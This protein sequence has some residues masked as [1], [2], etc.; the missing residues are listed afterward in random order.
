MSLSDHNGPPA[1]GTCTCAVCVKMRAIDVEIE[2]F[3]ALP[4]ARA[5]EM[6]SVGVAKAVDA[7]RHPGK[8]TRVAVLT[9]LRRMASP[10]GDDTFHEQAIAAK[11]FP[12]PDEACSCG[13]L[14]TSCNYAV[15]GPVHPKTGRPTYHGAY[16]ADQ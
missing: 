10:L 12:F 8:L 16:E 2:R 11:L 4:R 3:R 14:K 15:L 9:G 6:E 13:R 5:S 1:P 7:I